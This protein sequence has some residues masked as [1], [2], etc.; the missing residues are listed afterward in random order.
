M[1]CES[2][3]TSEQTTFLGRNGTMKCGGINV[4]EMNE[5][6]DIRPITSRNHIGR[7]CITIPQKDIPSLIEILKMI[8]EK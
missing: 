7:C 2:F 5:L 1:K 8:Q 6:V 4:L 3:K